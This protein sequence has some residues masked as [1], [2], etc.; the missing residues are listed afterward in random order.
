MTTTIERPP[1]LER[2]RVID[3]MHP[4]VICC[5]LETPLPTVARMMATYRVHAIIVIAHESDELEGGTLWGVISDGDLMQAAQADEFGEQTARSLAATPPLTIT[6]KESLERAVQLM[7]AH[8]VTHLIVI[9]R[10]SR[11][12]IGVVSTLDVAMALSGYAAW[13]AAERDP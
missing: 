8:E 2:F 4:G 6:S 10:H 1:A 7:V 12:P 11:R 5:P 13:P 9:E 3:V